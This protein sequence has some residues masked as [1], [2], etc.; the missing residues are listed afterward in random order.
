MGYI[1][2]QVLLTVTLPGPKKYNSK[3][4]QNYHETH[5]IQDFSLERVGMIKKF[6]NGVYIP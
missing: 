2:Y 6:L 1:K 4:T 3:A 5:K